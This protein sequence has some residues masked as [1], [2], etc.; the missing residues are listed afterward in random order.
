MNPIL[1]RYAGIALMNGGETFKIGG[2]VSVRFEAT[3][4]PGGDWFNAV[5]VYLLKDGDG[6]YSSTARLLGN[7]SVRPGTDIYAFDWKIWPGEYQPG[8]YRIVVDNAYDGWAS[9]P[10]YDKSDAA[11]RIVAP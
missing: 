1:L 10:E 5:S 2:T 6:F 4:M 11:F 8:G 3:D 7:V 9:L